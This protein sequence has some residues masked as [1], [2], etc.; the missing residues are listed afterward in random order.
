MLAEWK[1]VSSSDVFFTEMFYFW[2]CACVTEYI[3]SVLLF[4]Y[5]D[6]LVWRFHFFIEYYHVDFV[7]ACSQQKNTFNREIPTINF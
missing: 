3:F 4:N 6:V 1:D 7:N 5:C 2:T